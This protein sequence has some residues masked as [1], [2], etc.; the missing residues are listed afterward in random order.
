MGQNLSMRTSGMECGRASEM[1]HAAKDWKDQ[2]GGKQ[3]CLEVELLGKAGP[4]DGKL[5]QGVGGGGE[6][7]PELLPPRSPFVRWTLG[8]KESGPGNTLE[9]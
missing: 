1:P 6:G 2:A 5:W 4:G 7:G 8:G 9:A 3:R